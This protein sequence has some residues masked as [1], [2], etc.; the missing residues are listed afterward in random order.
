MEELES[1]FKSLPLRRPSSRLDARVLGQKPKT[2]PTPAGGRPGWALRWGWG[3]AAAIPALLVVYAWLSPPAEVRSTAWSNVTAAPVERL[4]ADGS[5]LRVF[6]EARVAWDIGG[7]ERW[8][9]LYEGQVELDVAAMDRLFAV[10]TPTGIVE[11]TGTRFR[12][13]VYRAPSQNQSEIEG[14]AP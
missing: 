7:K 5:R 11:V 8:V 3:L 9:E 10:R 4:L 1:R 12:V 2:P 14:S 6:P 13:A